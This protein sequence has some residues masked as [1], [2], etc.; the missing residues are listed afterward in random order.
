MQLG[1]VGGRLQPTSPKCVFFLASLPVLLWGCQRPAPVV[2]KPDSGAQT[3]A[4][5]DTVPRDRIADDTA[6]FLAGMPGNPGSSFSTWEDNPAWREHR[7]LLD[8]AWASAEDKLIHGL[9]EFQQSE[10]AGAPLDRA[11]VFYPFAGPDALT[12]IACFPHSPTYLLVALEPVGTLP[13]AQQLAR[14]PLDRYLDGVRASL[15]SEL[16]KSFFVTR[17]MDRQFRGQITD[18]LL[19]P[20]LVLLV[21]TDHTI[22]GIRHV[23]INEEGQVVEWPPATKVSGKFPNHGIEIQF[24]TNGD[25][26]T[27]RLNYFSVNLANPRLSGNWGFLHYATGIEGAVTMLKA[28][29]YMPHHTEFSMIRD[30]VLNRSQAIFQDDS[31]I[32]YHCFAADQWNVQLYGDYTRPYGSFRWLEQADLRKAYLT[33]VVKPLSLRLG[34]GFGKVTS[35]LLLARRVRGAP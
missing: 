15:A 29:S 5:A 12:P 4:Q 28:T 21:R 10:L 32:P 27:H 14:K 30:L 6:R 26:T 8:A 20:I 35:N 23:R 7:Q 18:G 13:S 34:Y 1:S 25:G 24:R 16:G 2:A 3:A 9:R 11:A 33:A 22:L 31:G 19:V 17:E